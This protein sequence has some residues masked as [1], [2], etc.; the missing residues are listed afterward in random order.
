MIYI[1]KN[2]KRLIILFCGLLVHSF[3]IVSQN[4]L[5]N[6]K[7]Y[8]YYK[9]RLN[10][11]FIKIG[12][13]PPSGSN[14]ENSPDHGESMPFNERAI[15]GLLP[16]AFYTNTGNELKLG[17]AGTRMGI[18]ISTLAT[19][20]R[21][22]KN[23]FQDVTKV[24]HELFCALNAVNRIDYYAESIFSNG[25][26]SPD[27]NGFFIRDDMPPNFVKNN[28]R[29]FNYYSENG[30]D[31]I[32]S[33]DRENDKGFTQTF[34]SGQDNNTSD[35][36]SYLSSVLNGKPRDEQLHSTEESQD[37]VFYLLMGLAL[38]SQLV[39]SGEKDGNNVFGYGSGE[40][41]LKIE[42]INIADR[43]IKHI[44]NSAGG[45]WKIRNPANGNAFTQIGWDASVYAYPLD[46][47]GCFIKYGQ[48]LPFI[49]Y[50]AP[51]YTTPLNTCTDYR[52]FHSSVTAPP[53]WNTLALNDGGTTVD[54]QGFF[55]AL[56]GIC[57]CVYED[58]LFKNLNVQQA[59]SDVQNQ[60]NQLQNQL[61]NIINNFL[62]NL[63]PWVSESA[64]WVQN[65]ISNISSAINSIVNVL[66]SVISQM[67]LNLFPSFKTNTTD[68]KLVHNTYFN[69]VNYTPIG[70]NSPTAFH[71]GSDAYFG[72]LLRDVLH[73]NT[74]IIQ[75]PNWLQFTVPMP[76]AGHLTIKNDMK[77]ILNGAPCE[78]NYNRY[79]NIPSSPYWGASNR[80]DRIDPIWKANSSEGFKG[81]YNGTDYMLLH[82]LYYLRE[83]TT[84]PFVD[85]SEK[86]VLQN[87]P[88]AG[89]FS[90]SNKKTL[91]AYEYIN[92]YNTINS[93][94]AADYR[95]GKEIA[96]LPNFSAVQG[97][98]FSAYIAPYNCSAAGSNINR[99]ANGA[100]DDGFN[101]EPVK[102]NFNQ[103][104]QDSYAQNKE[105]NLQSDNNDLTKFQSQLDSLVK[106][107]NEIKMFTTKVEVYPNPNNGE[108]SIEF[109]L[110]PED[111]VDVIIYDMAGMEIYNQKHIIGYLTLPMNLKD[112]AKGIY[113]VRFK[114]SNGVEYYKKVN[115][116]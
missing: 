17:D 6:H 43:I 80:I 41:E 58:M 81:D 38:T 103:K 63:P 27:L 91:G 56:S 115:V 65:F 59:I 19:E 73:P 109:N 94:G 36:I 35:Y 42:A 47:S 45:L 72:I 64:G 49:F 111:N 12:N 46:N 4:D 98:D 69:N 83:G 60:I 8:W 44:K 15:E 52:N 79:P 88:Y 105:Q 67:L 5:E 1:L 13:T 53:V 112:Y 106:N 61:N 40:T 55:H 34:N 116:Q 20:Y 9:T 33:I 11:D 78:G 24:K 50:S 54:M 18:Y 77:V 14:D 26:M 28:Y 71:L 22:L 10:N 87:M 96:L 104:K 84:S 74:G 95:A 62:N 68:V 23:N 93:N 51:F 29:H 100:S 2:K 39:D 30:I 102:N 108:F 113:V 31:G 32:G 107:A 75:L 48:D 16:G 110:S 101:D 85:Y 76:T 97:S 7:K 66:Q 21:L 86:K 70:G 57:N 92:A 3:E 114:N 37:Q 90:T 99:T 25:N 82:N 89:I